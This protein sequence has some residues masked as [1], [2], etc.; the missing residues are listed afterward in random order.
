[1]ELYNSIIE[2]VPGLCGSTPVKRYAYDPARAWPDSGEF[3]LVMLRDAA[4]ELGGGSRSAVNFTC[5]TTSP[6]LIDKDEIL[7]CGPDLG[8]LKA[9]ADYARITLLRVGDIESDDENDTE[10][11]FRAI[12]DMDFVKYHVFPRGYMIRTSSES[13]R[14]QV[15]ISKEALRGGVSFE[16]VG[17]DF[18]RQYKKNPSIL[19]VRMLFI[20]APG[21]DHARAKRLAKNVKDITLSLTKILEGMP[22]DCG[23]CQLKPICD[24]V[25]GLKELHF[26]KEKGK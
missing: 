3:E 20:T 10:S 19:N 6:K 2:Q 23:S 7:V 14:E 15:R 12:Q 24:E 11:A 18:I 21:A 4:F 17:D 26:G 5:V 13:S 25:E 9:D 16:R 8:E 1:M 22:T